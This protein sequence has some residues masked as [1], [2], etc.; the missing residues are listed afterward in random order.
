MGHT[1]NYFNGT[2]CGDRYSACPLNSQE[3]IHHIRVIAEADMLS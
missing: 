3:V 1:D 2:I